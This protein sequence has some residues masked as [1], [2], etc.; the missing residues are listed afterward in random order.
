[1]SYRFR[2]SSDSPGKDDNVRFTTVPLKALCEQVFVFV[3]LNR[4]FSF[5][6]RLRFKGYQCKSGTLQILNMN[7][8]KKYK[9]VLKSKLLKTLIIHIKLLCAKLKN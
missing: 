9:N 4:L 1:M 5:L 3:S 2:I 6:I 7:L 8:K